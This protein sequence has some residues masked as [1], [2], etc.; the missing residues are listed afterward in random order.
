MR[1]YDILFVIYVSAVIF[2]VRDDG[3][4]FW[5]ICAAHILV[6]ILA[7]WVNFVEKWGSK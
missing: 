3:W 5:A 1:V 6:H 2:G 7:A 4:A